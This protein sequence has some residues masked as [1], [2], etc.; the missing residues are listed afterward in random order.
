MSGILYKTKVYTCGFMENG[1]GTGWRDKTKSELSKLGIFV[2][3]PYHRVFFNGTPEDEN[4]RTNLKDMM[5]DGDFES[6]ASHM[7]KVRGEDLRCVDLSDFIIAYID[8]KIPTWGTMEELSW[9][10][11]CKKPVFVVVKDGVE[12]TPL[13]LLG[14]FPVKY[15]YNNLNDALN[16]IKKIDEGLVSIDSGCW[17]ILKQEY[18]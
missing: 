6:V 11:R 2:L 7:K 9:A 10:E 8:P 14:M 13:W 12:H 17:R 18:R 15:F 5:G 4:A 16:M 1:N 3:D